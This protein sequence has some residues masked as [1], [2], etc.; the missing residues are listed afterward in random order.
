MLI[1]SRIISV[2]FFAALLAP[3]ASA[4]AQPKSTPDANTGAAPPA[5]E[6]PVASASI[7]QLVSAQCPKFS[8]Q[9]VDRP[10]LKPILGQ[11]PVDIPAV[12]SCTQRS[13][14]ADTRLQRAIDVKD[15][16]LVERMKDERMR[17]YL[18]I[19]L[20]ASVL[21]CLTPELERALTAVPPLK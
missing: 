9:L 17:A 18:T 7:P 11:R 10:E 20:M 14:L 13:F 16:V 2:A 6:A 19:R 1:R 21:E 4:I 3:G 12:C 5:A 8:S 15:E